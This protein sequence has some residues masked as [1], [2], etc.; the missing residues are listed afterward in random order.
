MVGIPLSHT[1][2]YTLVGIP[3]S[4]TLKYTLV[5]ICLSYYPFVG[6][7]AS[8]PPL[9]HPFHCWSV[10][11]ACCTSLS[12]CTF[13]RKGGTGRPLSDINTR[14]TVGQ[15]LCLPFSRFTVGLDLGPPPTRFTVGHEERHP[16]TTRFTVGH[17]RGPF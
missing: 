8:F 6:K 4:H 14:F 17:E 5:Y 2:R 16:S 7:E 3:L 11:Y 9:Y 10:L 12:M 1:P 13:R 15:E